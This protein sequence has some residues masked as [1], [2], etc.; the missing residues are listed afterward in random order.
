MQTKE[1]I[2]PQLVRGVVQQ[3]WRFLFTDGLKKL[4]SFVKEFR[5]W[6]LQ[7]NRL[8]YI[9]LESQKIC[10]EAL[11]S[12]P[13]MVLFSNTI[14]CEH[15]LRVLDRFIHYGQHT[16]IA[17]VKNVFIKM[18]DKLL[19]IRDPFD[20]NRYMS[21]QMFL[22]A[23]NEKKFFPKMTQQEYKQQ[24]R[25]MMSTRLPNDPLEL[26]KEQVTKLVSTG[27]DS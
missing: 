12:S 27:M 20:L 7:T 18:Q 26:N 3:E 21:K 17:I 24:N 13:F 11:L 19:K 15:S 1:K 9:H 10:L 5:N 16:L 8:L 23:I 4:N 6:L 25:L 2:N 22:D 14:P